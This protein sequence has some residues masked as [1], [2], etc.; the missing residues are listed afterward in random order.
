ML[1]PQTYMLQH[2]KGAKVIQNLF[3]ELR[4]IR[5]IKKEARENK[6][7]SAK[8]AS[9]LAKQMICQFPLEDGPDLSKQFDWLLSNDTKY[10]TSLKITNQKKGDDVLKPK[11]GPIDLSRSMR[12]AFWLNT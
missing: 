10:E 2:H 6:R 9:L 8:Q 1:C 12:G 4:T 11:V 7:R 3:K 5:I